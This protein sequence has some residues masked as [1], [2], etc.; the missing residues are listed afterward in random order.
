MYRDASSIFPKCASLTLSL[1][2]SLSHSLSLS[3]SMQMTFL[4]CWPYQALLSSSLMIQVSNF[5]QPLA[6]PG[7]GDLIVINS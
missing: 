4:T 1:P 5:P 6:S 2:V 3:I 7:S